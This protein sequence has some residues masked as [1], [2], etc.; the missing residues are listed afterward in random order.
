MRKTGRTGFRPEKN[1]TAGKRAEYQ[2]VPARRSSQEHGKTVPHRQQEQ[3]NSSL[4]GRESLFLDEKIPADA[5][6]IIESFD[7]IVQGVKPLN[8]RQLNSLPENI[9][10]LSHLLTDTRGE[11][12]MGYL[13][14]N[15]M[16]S[17]YTRYFVWWNLVRLVRLF[18]NLPRGAFPDRDCI[19]LDAGSGPLTVVTALWLARPE[20]RNLNLVWYCLDISQNSLSLGEDLY[21]SVAAKT[22]PICTETGN[23]PEP[24]WKIIRI[25]GNFGTVIRQKASFITC[26]NMLNEADQASDMPPEFQAKKYFSQFIEYA[27][28]NPK[29]LLVEPGVPKAARTLSLLRGYFIKNGFGI[30]SPCPH[31]GDCPMNGF[32]AFTGSR[33]KWC[34]F[35][36]STENAPAALQ[37]LSSAAKLP[38]ERAVLSFLAAAK[39]ASSNT[40]PQN[41]LPVRITS[42]SIKLPGNSSGHYACGKDGLYLVCGDGGIM[43]GDLLRIIPQKKNSAAEKDGKTGAVK[44]I[45]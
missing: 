36:F 38:K 8:S 6:K 41:E 3:A 37:K 13:N 7:S 17:A 20:L 40:A 42:D 2:N 19:C 21:L 11:R 5:R 39:Q 16:L 31:D 32:K 24:H 35:A 23:D 15:I 4:C 44:L 28:A 30:T 27:D 33:N 18:S 9:R 29:F 34:N 45:L 12:R 26:A 1:R 25:K 43:S 22:P 14:E 10:N